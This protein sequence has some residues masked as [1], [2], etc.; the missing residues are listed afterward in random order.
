M[1]KD[2]YKV[3][4]VDKNVDNS[5]LKKA[6]RKLAIKY[7]PDKNPDDKVSEEKFKEA[8]EAYDVLSD[9][10]K[11]QNYDTYGTTDGRGGNPFGGG[12]FDMGDIFS[13][14]FGEEGN[15]FGGGNQRQKRFKGTDI[16]VNIKLSLEDVYSGVYK[17]IKYKR[18]VS[19][20]ECK[21]TGGET[22]KCT[23]CNGMGRINRVSNTP[24]G[25]IQ[26]T[27]ICPTCNG[28]GN[29]IVKACK[30]CNG[31]GVNLKEETTDFQIPKGIMDGEYLVLSG[32][33]N[34]IKQGNSGDLIINIVE[35][36]HD[37]FKRKKQDIHQRINLSFKDLVLG[38][39]P[40]LVTLDGKIRIKVKEGTE[41]GHILRVPKKGLVREGIIGDMMVEV[42]I[43]I[44]KSLNEENKR[45]IESLN[46]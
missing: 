33:G 44:P 46:I 25:K 39:S 40:E 1:T 15:P 37:I 34:S 11:R 7:H 5:T 24:F 12:G 42:W 31:I 45:T 10:K 6:Y 16:R 14:F 19:C 27:V 21:S 35:V 43:D 20:T 13:S 28:D 41:V 23:M 26:N 2:Y 29:V 30:K 17:K 32:K 3:L 22:S 8:A 36:P 18:N 9:P 4:G 38:C